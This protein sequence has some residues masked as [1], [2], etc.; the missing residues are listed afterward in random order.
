MERIR[1][2]DMVEIIAGNDRGKRG[3]VL[4]MV[5]DKG[6]VVVQGINLR[7]K[8]MRKSQQSPQGGRMRREV[9]IQLSNVMLFDEGAQV[10]SRIGFKMEDGKK[11]RVLR[12]TGAVVGSAAPPEKKT[13]KKAAKKT[14][15]KAAEKES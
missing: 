2:D 1:K 4:R 8:H 5:R 6:R 15:K 10:R 7:W 13:K 3:R 14:A 9:P 11:V 12:K